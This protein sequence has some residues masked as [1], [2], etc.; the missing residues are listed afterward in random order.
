[1]TIILLADGSGGATT[2][3][4][5]ACI[6]RLVFTCDQALGFIW[7]YV[8]AAEAA[9][10]ASQMHEWSVIKLICVVCAVTPY[11]LFFNTPFF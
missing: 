9:P 7:D 5:E 8:G 1:M 6:R 2:G 11:L 10:R 3:D 4:A